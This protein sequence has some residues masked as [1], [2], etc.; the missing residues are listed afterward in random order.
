MPPKRNNKRKNTAETSS[1]NGS[2]TPLQAPDPATWPG[3]VEMES[4]PVS[5]VEDR[6]MRV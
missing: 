5:G 3:W 4:E 2:E 6:K 1:T